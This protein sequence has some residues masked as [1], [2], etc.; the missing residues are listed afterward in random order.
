MANFKE[1]TINAIKSLA[2]NTHN[3][4]LEIDELCVYLCGGS[5]RGYYDQIG[6]E[7]D[8]DKMAEGL[9]LK[10]EETSEEEIWEYDDGYGLQVFDGWITFK[11]SN[12]WIERKEY[13]GSE[14]WEY[15]S[16]PSLEEIRKEREENERKRRE[17]IE[18][19]PEFLKEDE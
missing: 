2:K 19:H 9:N 13:D 16:K 3:E 14:W 18:K 1:E 17:W 4:H 6:G 10:D 8:W 15:I 11:N 12:Y 5:G 7:I